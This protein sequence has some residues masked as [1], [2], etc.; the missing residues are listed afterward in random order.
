MAIDLRDFERAEASFHRSAEEPER[1]HIAG[2]MHQIT[3]QEDGGEETQGTQGIVR[4]GE[5]LYHVPP[6]NEERFAGESEDEHIQADKRDGGDR[7]VFRR[8]FGAIGQKHSS[9]PDEQ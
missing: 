8:V 6:G 2:Q 5:I 9:S 1:E 4:E 3:V 7:K